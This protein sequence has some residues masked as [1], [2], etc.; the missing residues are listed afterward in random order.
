MCARPLAASCRVLCSTGPGITGPVVAGPSRLPSVARLP[1]SAYA[2]QRQQ[3]QHTQIRHITLPHPDLDPSKGATILYVKALH[4]FKSMVE[5][6]AVVRAVEAQFGSVLNVDLLKDPDSLLPTSSMHLT[7]LRPVQIQR[8]L[9]LEIPAPESSLR[10]A[11]L[12]GPSLED[13]REVLKSNPTASAS[14]FVFPSP[15][16]EL[17][18][19][20]LRSGWRRTDQVGNTDGGD[21]TRA[22]RKAQAAASDKATVTTKAS[23]QFSVKVSDRN[24]RPRPTSSIRRRSRASTADEREMDIE[25]VDSL[26]RFG[27]GFFGGFEGLAEDFEHLKSENKGET[28]D[29]KAG[30]SGQG[31]SIESSQEESGGQTR[32]LEQYISDEKE[33]A[34]SSA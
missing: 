3:V 27:G 19:S 28:D 11:R 21:A 17:S 13:V 2:Q 9:M 29:R 15:K 4:P 33:A 34:T 14:D 22:H 25:V 32:K 8:P 18:T 24:G 10:K 30:G 26:K 23:I 20:T 6:F 5:A 31:H 12:G 7:L 1:Q 16:S